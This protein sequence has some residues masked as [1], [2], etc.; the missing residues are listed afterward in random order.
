[1]TK[2]A[3]LL[4]VAQPALGLQIR[5]LEEQMSTPLLER[6]SRGV[7]VTPAGRLLYE[8]AVTILALFEQAEAEVKTFARSGGEALALGITHS[9]MRLVGSELLIAAR[10][11]LPN[12]RFTL[13]EEPSTV[14]ARELENDDVHL[15][16]AYDIAE[17][18]AIALTPIMAEELLLVV[19]PRH[20]PP[21]ESVTLEEA[22]GFE[23]VLASTRDPIRSLVDAR[24]RQAGLEVR[25]G[26]EAQSL[27]ASRQVVLDGLAASILPYGVVAEEF[28]QGRLVTRRLAG[29][30]L[31]RTL[32]L[33]RSARRGAF[34]NEDRIMRLIRSVIK[35]L[36]L[37]LGPLARL[38][39]G[40]D[41]PPL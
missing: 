34:V 35:Q 2:A 38:V 23:M 11:D 19:H 32:Y 14:L 10:R 20:A 29:Q 21:G 3:T 12:V 6:H 22:L 9:I 18:P 40:D 16:L 25:V 24:A 15:A 5:Q 39:E 41:R 27:V 13:V 26:Y 37:D 8:R 28:E 17:S 7:S 33:A 1:M 31:V 4:N 36:V 30:P